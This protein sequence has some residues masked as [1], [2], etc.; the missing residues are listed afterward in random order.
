[1]SNLSFQ[2]NTFCREKLKTNTAEMHVKLHTATGSEIRTLIFG[3]Q[4]TE[5]YKIS[6]RISL[7]NGLSQATKIYNNVSTIQNGLNYACQKPLQNLDNIEYLAQ[8]DS[9]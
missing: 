7:P 3:W 6:L 5:L 4:F 2:K 9:K 8:D 1:M